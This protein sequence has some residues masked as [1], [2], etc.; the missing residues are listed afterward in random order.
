VKRLGLFL[1]LVL[2]TT[3]SWSGCSWVFV[4]PL[5]DRHVSG[6]F[7]DCT[8][9]PAAPVIDTLFAL[10]NL[11]SAIY[12]GGQDSPNKG[13]AM[14]AGALFGALWLSSAVYGYFKTSDCRDAQADYEDRPRAHP[15]PRA[16]PVGYPPGPTGGGRSAPV[17]PSA[18]ATPGQQEDDDEPERR[19]APQ[20]PAGTPNLP[21][22]GHSAPPARN[23]NVPSS[24][25]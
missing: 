1:A 18:P 22:K 3:A 13:A 7:A 19:R 24:G 21:S 17:P 15:L 2:P 25:A 9:S 6:D 23:P 11:G 20:Q 14:T 8:T 5:P 10:T 16:R 4:E 12:V